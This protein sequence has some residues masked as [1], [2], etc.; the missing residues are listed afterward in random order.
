M[1][2][3]AA[4]PTGAPATGQPAAAAPPPKT[5]GDVLAKL[6]GRAQYD[7]PREPPAAP[8]A[9][10]KVEIPGDDVSLKR[11]TRLEADNLAAK[12]RIAQLEGAEKD[13]ALLRD[14]RKLYGEGKKM[15]AIGMLAGADPSGELEEL[16]ASYLEADK[17][18]P[19]AATAEAAL[20]A[21][22]DEALQTGKKAQEAIEALRKEDAAKADKEDRSNRL[23]FALQALDGA[24]NDD[25]TP[26]FELC[27]RQENRGD[28]EKLLFGYAD[29]KGV[30]QMGHVQRLA[31]KQGV[32]SE[33]VTPEL[34]RKLI[35]AAYADIE[36][37]LEAEGLEQQ[38]AIDARYKKAPRAGA[39][40]G[41]Q[42]QNPQRVTPPVAGSVQE[43][44][45]E[46][47]PRPMQ[48]PP[49]RVAE[50][51]PVH[52]LDA[53]MAKNRERARY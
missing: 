31:V 44:Q 17:G 36:A 20:A 3:P 6:R 53:V 15:E 8:A 27:S 24:K 40:D 16:L 41:R 34:A 46:P 22:V 2:A 26:Q 21:K 7:T 52:S 19:A 23:G 4:E 30:E 12:E 45:R 5:F 47:Q 37:E 28:L 25:G 10:T 43:P 35:L 39:G 1:S 32:K 51:K 29:D 33:D 11:I 13:A 49:V 42:P 9:A 48:K 38:K 14:V 18:T 50:T